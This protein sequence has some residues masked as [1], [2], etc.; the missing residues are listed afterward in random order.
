VGVNE[1]RFRT[2]N[3]HAA[4]DLASA[5]GNINRDHSLS[6]IIL[7]A[8]RTLAGGPPPLTRFPRLIRLVKIRDPHAHGVL[9]D[10]DFA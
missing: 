7:F 4:A 9:Q 1:T 6:S 10:H 8:V 3:A 5:L 2:R